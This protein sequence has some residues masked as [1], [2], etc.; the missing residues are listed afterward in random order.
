MTPWIK[1][2]T[3]F[4]AQYG[5]VRVTVRDQSGYSVTVS[6]TCPLVA[7]CEAWKSYYAAAGKFA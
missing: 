3:S 4:S 5:L 6:S 1:A 2:V 7:W